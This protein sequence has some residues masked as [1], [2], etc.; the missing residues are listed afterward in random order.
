VIESK[1]Q[2]D[3]EFMTVAIREAEAALAKEEIPIGAVVVKDGMIISRSHNQKEFLNNP[4]AHAEILALSQAAKEI[5]NWRLVGCTI[6]VTLEP[7]PM[8]AG[9][10]QQ[11][12]IARLVYGTADKKA[13]AAGSLMNLVDHP[14]LNHRLR[15]TS[16]VE[17]DKCQ[18][19][20]NMFFKRLRQ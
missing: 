6:Y 9:A 12:R 17:A 16:G 3:R 5:K 8:C 10:I 19:L 20:L 15:I 1:L 4:T 11:A 18:K 14:S 13:G 2:F 7:C